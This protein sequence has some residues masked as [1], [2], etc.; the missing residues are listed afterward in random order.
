MLGS[1]INVSIELEMVFSYEPQSNGIG[2]IFSTAISLY[3]LLIVD[4]EGADWISQPHTPDI[5]EHS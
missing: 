1:K 2:G 4:L 5:K 3:E